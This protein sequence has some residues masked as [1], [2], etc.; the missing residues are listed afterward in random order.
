MTG[1]RSTSARIISK[2]RLPEPEHDR[3]SQLDD[4]NARFPKDFARLLAAAQVLRQAARALS[5]TAEVDDPP[6]AGRECRLAEDAR[7]LPVA[8]GE[9]LAAHRMDQVVGG[10]DAFESPRRGRGV[11]RV[12][13]GDLRRGRRAAVQRFGPAH[14]ATHR[15]ASPLELGEQ[16]PADVARGAGQ[17]HAGGRHGTDTTSAEHGLAPILR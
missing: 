12:A 14:E 2:E 1:S 13:S 8:R 10:V 3:G 4:G 15:Y 17:E 7:G 6:D 16:S 11:E 9:I 5:Q